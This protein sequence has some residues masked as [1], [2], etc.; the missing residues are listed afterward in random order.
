L[1]QEAP[2]ARL[3]KLEGAVVDGL[4]DLRPVEIDGPLCQ[5]NVDGA[6][7]MTFMSVL[8]VQ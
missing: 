1:S 6:A 8:V 3:E 7:E 2:A 5:R 4:H